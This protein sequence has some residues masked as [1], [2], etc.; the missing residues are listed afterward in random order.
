[1]KQPFLLLAGCGKVDKQR[2][3]PRHYQIGQILRKVLR[4]ARRG[5]RLP[6]E[7]EMAKTF[8]VSPLTLR[9]ALEDLVNEGVLEKVWGRGTYVRKRLAPEKDAARRIGM[10]V[11]PNPEFINHPA[12]TEFMRGICNVLNQHACRLELALVT[13][14]MIRSGDYSGIS[15]AGELSGLIVTLQQVPGKDL[16]NISR[17]AA[18]SVL[19]NRFDRADTVMFD[20]KSASVLL[21]RHLVELG[22]RRIAL[23]NGPDYS[24]VSNAVREGYAAVMSDAGVPEY[25]RQIKS[26]YYTAEEGFRLAQAVCEAKKRPTALIM[27]D[28]T[29]AWG[30]LE[31]LRAMGL[32]CPE[33]V[34]VVSFGDFPLARAA[35]PPLTAVQTLFYEMGRAL[36]A[37]I[38]EKINGKAARQKVVIKG[39]LIVRQ[40]TCKP[41]G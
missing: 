4:G 34:S 11:L 8:Q 23:L 39:K 14:E 28:D 24:E 20:Y 37:K 36:A 3:V 7:R 17:Q 2:A 38:L 27:G 26:S 25:E 21:T 15:R 31:A 16:D 6:P 9:R 29:M 32:K 33:Q 5:D 13:P 19:C 18:Y 30:A 40:S 1:M 41:G 10:T 35:V 12:Q 22:H